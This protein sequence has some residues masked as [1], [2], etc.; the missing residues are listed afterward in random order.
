MGKVSKRAQKGKYQPVSEA[1][2][3]DP[4]VFADPLGEAHK[5]RI[6]AAHAG[7]FKP[8]ENAPKT[9]NPVTDAMNQAKIDDDKRKAK[10]LKESAL[11]KGMSEDKE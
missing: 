6:A 7:T 9:G 5:A 2:K 1:E 10:L 4:K 8:N 3:D 11:L